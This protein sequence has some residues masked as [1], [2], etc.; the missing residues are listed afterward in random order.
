MKLVDTPAKLR[1]ARRALGWT[2]PYL[3]E[4]LGLTRDAVAKMEAGVRPIERRT[5]L[6]IRYLLER[7]APSS[8]TA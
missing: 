4:E 5:D 8:V 2:Q 3:A 6:A 1:A 7:E